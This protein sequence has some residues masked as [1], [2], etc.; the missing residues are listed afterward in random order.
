[1]NDLLNKLV[2]AKNARLRLLLFAPLIK[3]PGAAILRLTL[4]TQAAGRRPQMY[5]KVSAYR[6]SHC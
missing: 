4:L 6:P 5:A 2:E 1:M 3:T